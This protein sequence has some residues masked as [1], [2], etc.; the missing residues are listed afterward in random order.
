MPNQIQI[1]LEQ[2]FEPFLNINF[3][4]KY[5]Q[6]DHI[7]A[8]T[9]NIHNSTYTNPKTLDKHIYIINTFLLL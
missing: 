2:Y 6:N 4:G 3:L 8:Y 9:C 1:S 7:M 5:Y